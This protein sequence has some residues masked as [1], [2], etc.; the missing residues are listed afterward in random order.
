M[1][2]LNWVVIISLQEESLFQNKVR[3]YCP[4][5]AVRLNCRTATKTFRSSTLYA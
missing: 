4:F 5:V 2:I 3:V 1:K